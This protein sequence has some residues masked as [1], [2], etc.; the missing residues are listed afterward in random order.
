MDSALGWLRRSALAVGGGA[1]CLVTTAQAGSVC[2]RPLQAPVAALGLAVTVDNGRIGG[3]YPDL[4]SGLDASCS[5]NYSLVPRA[6]LQRLFEIGKAD[7]L[8]PGSRTPERDAYATFVPVLAARPVL[9]TLNARGREPVRSVADLMARRDLRVAVVRGFNFGA[10][11]R[12][13]TEALASQGRLVPTAEVISVARMLDEG[14]A[15]ATLM[16]SSI[17]LGA[18]LGDAKLRALVPRLRNEPL[19]ELPWSDTG[20][21]VSRRSGLS[22]QDQRAIIEQIEALTR[23]GRAWAIFHK[24]FPPGSLNDSIRPHGPIK[25]EGSDAQR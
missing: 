6:R 12:Q 15:D 23:S 22:E 21:Y 13:I 2:S 18:I 5:I 17:L 7:L 9:I 19:N 10:E 24:R 11:Y 4:L 3:I 14:I 1:L 16:N 8:I 20:I 25:E